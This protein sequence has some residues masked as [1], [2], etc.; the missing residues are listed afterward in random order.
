AMPS[1]VLATGFFLFLNDT[2]GLPASPYGLVVTTNAL[3]AI[4]Y[5]LKILENPMLDMAQSYNLLCQSLDLRGW[6][7][8]RLIELCALQ[9]PIAQAMAFACVLSVGDFGIIALF[10]NEQFRTLP[11]YLYQQ[12][13]AYHSADGA[14][15]AL[16]LMLLCFAL[17]TVM[18]KLTLWQKRAGRYAIVE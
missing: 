3:I 4:P 6:H 2:A 11:F 5:A 12:I 17:F 13:G 14:V 1:I 7:R 18:E 9:Q 16:L 15:T 10:G 8:L